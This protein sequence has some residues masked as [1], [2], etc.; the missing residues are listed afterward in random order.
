DAIQIRNQTL[1]ARSDGVFTKPSFRQLIL[2]RRCIVPVNGFYENRDVAG[3]KY[4]YFIYKADEDPLLLGGIWNRWT[5]A[6]TGEVLETFTIITTDANPLMRRIHNS[7]LRMPLIIKPEDKNRW[8]DISIKKD[9]VEQMM[10]PYAGN[11]L[12]AHTVS[13]LVNR[14]KEFTNVPEVAAEVV[15]PELTAIDTAP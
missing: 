4:P 8:L 2:K 6:E 10:Q 13:K 3:K 14:K 9:A 11:D 12:T 1:N 7:K 15:Y 5:D